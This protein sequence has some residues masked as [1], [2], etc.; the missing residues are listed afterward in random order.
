MIK[1]K[2]LRTAD[3]MWS[4]RQNDDGMVRDT[5]A[6]SSY[7]GIKQVSNLRLENYQDFPVFKWEQQ[8]VERHGWQLPAASWLTFVTS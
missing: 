3:F 1:E 6:E 7:P 2:N 5:E 4:T 8:V